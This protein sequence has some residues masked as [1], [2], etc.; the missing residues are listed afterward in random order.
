MR[1]VGKI[2]LYRW[3]YNSNFIA[4]THKNPGVVQKFGRHVGSDIHNINFNITNN[5]NFIVWLGPKLWRNI[6][7]RIRGRQDIDRFKLTNIRT[8][9]QN[10]LIILHD[11]PI[12]N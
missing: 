1:T 10:N 2:F 9:I 3:H 7:K 12:S 4:R 8:G 5:T 6:D 11:H